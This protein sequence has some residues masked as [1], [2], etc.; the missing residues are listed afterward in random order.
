MCP[1]DEPDFAILIQLVLELPEDIKKY[2]MKKLAKG[3]R[4]DT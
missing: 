3:S 4:Y 1:L 2:V